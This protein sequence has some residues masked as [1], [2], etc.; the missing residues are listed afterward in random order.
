M[1]LHRPFRIVQHGSRRRIRGCSIGVASRGMHFSH[2]GL[3]IGLCCIHQSG[4]AAEL[5]DLS[6]PGRFLFGQIHHI[7]PF[8]VAEA[9]SG[10]NQRA[11]NLRKD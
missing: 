10:R 6:S 11:R 1:Y 3:R 8:I 2:H 4:A 5:I 7:S 9:H